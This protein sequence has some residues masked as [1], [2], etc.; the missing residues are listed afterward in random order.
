VKRRPA[1]RT[2][3]LTEEERRAWLLYEAARITAPPDE[4]IADRLRFV[5]AAMEIAR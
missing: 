4:P 3:A 1:A 5:A 2:L